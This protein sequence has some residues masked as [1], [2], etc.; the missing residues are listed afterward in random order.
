MSLYEVRLTI[1]YS[2]SIEVEATDEKS[3][4]EAAKTTIGEI[5]FVVPD[6]KEYFSFQHDGREIE[7]YDVMEIE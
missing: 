2:V 5:D 7:V 3:A 1:E 4:E 6:A